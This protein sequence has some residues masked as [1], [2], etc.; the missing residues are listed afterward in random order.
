MKGF[1]LIEFL[2]YIAIVGVILV[3]I[4]G[5]LWNTILGNIKE[6]CYQEVQQNTRFALAKITQE[7]KKATGINSPLPGDSSNSLSLTMATTHLNPTVFDVVNGKLRITQGSGTSYYLTSDRV[8]VG[9]L[10]FTNLSYSETPGTIRIEM[11]LDHINPGN[12]TEYQ[13]SVSLKSSV[14][15]VPGGAVVSPPHL[16]QLHYRWRNDDGVE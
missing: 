7:I 8:R 5:F 15:L 12:R 11:T 1:T 10:Q 14:T 2:I 4:V 16:V 13:A 3:I 9:S 6:T